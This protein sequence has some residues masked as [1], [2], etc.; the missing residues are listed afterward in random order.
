MLLTAGPKLR[1]WYGEGERV[2]EEFLLDDADLSD[3]L[4]A[5]APSTERE[6]VLVTDADSP[7]GEQIILQLILAR[8]ALNTCAQAFLGGRLAFP[9]VNKTMNA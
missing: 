7:M 4:P 2:T 1:R 9:A 6:S 3:D 5:P 8:W